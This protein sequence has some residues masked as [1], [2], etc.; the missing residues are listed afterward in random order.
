MPC[1]KLPSG[2]KVTL[3]KYQKTSNH[4]VYMESDSA[5]KKHNILLRLVSAPERLDSHGHAVAKHKEAALPQAV[6]DASQT[7][8]P[9]GFTMDYC[10]KAGAALYHKVFGTPINTKC[11][12]LQ[13]DAVGLLHSPPRH[14]Q[15][16]LPS[17][18][19]N[20]IAGTQRALPTIAA[21]AV[22]PKPSAWTTNGAR[23]GSLRPIVRAFRGTTATAAAAAAA[24]PPPPTLPG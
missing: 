24:P 9:A 11:A 2:E 7:T 20:L 3:E 19:P 10:A 15:P 4:L 17:T 18:L 1:V 22:A 23:G 12:A 21:K 5:G 14:A 16:E 8:L 6:V 13:V